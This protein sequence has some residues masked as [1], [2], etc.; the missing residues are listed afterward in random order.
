MGPTLNRVWLITGCSTGFGRLFCE[1]LLILGERVVATARTPQTLE[2]L[3]SFAKDQKQ[4]LILKL[5]VTSSDQIK[6]GVQDALQHFGR[7][8][9]LVNN[10]GYGTTGA[11]EEVPE[12]EIREIFETN[13]FGLFEMTRAVLPQMRKQ[14]SG[15]IINLSSVAGMAALPGAGIYSATKFA[16][17]GMMEGLAGE[18]APFGI[19]VILLEPG[20]FR[21]DFAGRSLHV[22]KYMPEYAEGLA[23][24][25]KYYETIGGHQPGD[26]NK[27]VDAVLEVVDSPS[28]P[29]RLILGKIALERVQKKLAQYQKE[30]VTWKHLTEHSDF[31]A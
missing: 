31:D 2:S 7:I 9:I 21:T 1:R 15:H 5:D 17:E 12:N 6:Q 16:V 22:A 30:I 28:P 20:A 10:A 18:V 26:P 11:L 8:D 13:V 14:K 24:T 4:L 25:R 27:L 3:R 29:L 19:K 23:Q